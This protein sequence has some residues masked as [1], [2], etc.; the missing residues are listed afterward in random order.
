MSAMPEPQL[1]RGAFAEVDV[2]VSAQFSA[3]AHALQL[4]EFKV[5]PNYVAQFHGRAAC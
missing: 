5:G 3:A 2:V 4:L 1:L